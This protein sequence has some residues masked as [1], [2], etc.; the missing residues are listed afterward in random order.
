MMT[1]LDKIGGQVDLA[2]LVLI[3]MLSMMVW[4]FILA[5]QGEKF[6]FRRMLVDDNEKPS[7]LRILAVGAWAFSSW[8]LM[9]D[10]I[11]IQGADP[12]VLLIYLA[13][14]SGAPIAAKLVEALQ[15]KW[16]SPKGP[17]A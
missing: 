5:Q 7:M 3:A 17:L 14:W 6:D 8:V 9:R 16:T 13:F 2:G 10:A 15:A 12:Q 1:W 11:S 4:L